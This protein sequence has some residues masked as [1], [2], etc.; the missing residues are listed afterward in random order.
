M[1]FAQMV[2][3]NVFLQGKYVEI[4]IAPIGAYGSSAG[5]LPPSGYHPSR[6]AGG[7][8][9]FI[10]DAAMDGW[11]VGEPNYVGCYF[12]PGDPQEG[13]D[14][15]ING[16]WNRAWR[17]SFPP[18]GS[19]TGLSFSGT[20]LTLDGANTDY[21]VSGSK[22]VGVWEGSMGNLQIRQTTELDTNKVYFIVKVDLKNTGTTPLENI[23]YDRTVDPDQESSTP[24]P[25]GSWGTSST[26]NTIVYQP[27][28]SATSEDAMK[29]LVSASGVNWGD[30]TYLGLGAVD[31]RAKCYILPSGLNPDP[32]IAGVDLET[33]YNETAPGSPWGGGS[34][35]YEKNASVTN[36]IG[37]GLVFNI[38]TLMPGDSTSLAYA[39]ILRSEDLDSA[40][41]SLAPGWILDG[42]SFTSG[43]TLKKCWGAEVEVEIQG[44]GAYVWGEWEDLNGGPTLPAGR[45]NLVQM[46]H[47]PL[48]YRVIGTNPICPLSDTLIMTFIPEGDS[49]ILN[50][51]VCAGEVYDFMGDLKFQ[52]GTYV[53]MRK[54]SIGCDSIVVLNLIVDPLPEIALTARETEICEGEEA[55]LSLT[56]PSSFANYQWYKNGAP[57]MGATGHSYAAN[58]PGTYY[59]AGVSDRGCDAQS[60]KIEVVVNPAAS[61][62][63]VSVSEQDICNGDTVTL[64]SD[65]KAN[66]QYSW[67]PEALFRYTGGSLSPQATAVIP[68]TTEIH[69][70]AMNEYGCKAY[71]TVVVQAHPCCDIYIPSAFTPNNDGLNDNFFPVLQSGQ[72]VVALQIFARNGQMVYDNN[73]P[74][75]GWN[76]LMNNSG[77]AVPQGVYMYRFIYTCTDGEVYEAKG[78]VTVI[79]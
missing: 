65:N 5:T 7:E 46:E 73:E 14:V 71:D 1:S 58:S 11:D 21:Y 60:R 3:G 50:E 32:T 38:G 79:R 24:A 30:A 15:Q 41:N 34:Y 55:L 75:K 17:G 42:S 48:T 12:V 74:L 8:L 26:I 16:V 33:I 18:V 68:S 2:D 28:P 27:D 64:K 31:C 10:A 77:E 4:G 20:P 29:C 56:A 40:F 69:M 76:G 53:N 52:T 23:Y 22:K 6:A 37:I 72:V 66:Y 51:R 39:Y 70:T 35:L 19:G 47:T 44:G 45:S 43:D 49:V 63:I 62:S 54:T 61:G 57:I 13:W 59:V 9:G 78:D 25:G 67:S 36:D